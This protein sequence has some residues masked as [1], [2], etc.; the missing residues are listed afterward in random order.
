M[1]LLSFDPQPLSN[2]PLLGAARQLK[3]PETDIHGRPRPRGGACDI[4]AFEAFTGNQYYLP[5]I[6]K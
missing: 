2:S 1:D 5:L 3:C 6:G 4:G